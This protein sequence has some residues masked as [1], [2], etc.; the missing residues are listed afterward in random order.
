[1]VQDRMNFQNPFYKMSNPDDLQDFY[2]M[3]F[4]DHHHAG[5]IQTQACMHL[6]RGLGM[7]RSHYLQMGYRHNHNFLNYL[8][9]LIRSR[10]FH[11]SMAISQVFL[12]CH[13]P[14]LLKSCL[15]KHSNP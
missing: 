1:M 11:N 3:Q 4:L 14:S 9:D 15:N 2:H 8:Q 12:S 10:Q 6:N 5:S 7:I 13:S